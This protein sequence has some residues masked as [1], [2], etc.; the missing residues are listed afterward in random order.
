[1]LLR[2]APGSTGDGLRFGLA[3]GRPRGRA[4]GEVYAR[5]DARAPRADRAEDFVR[6]AQLYARHA[7]VV[8]ERGERFE[9]ATWSEVDV[10]QWTARQPRARAW[11]R[12]P[13][14]RLGERVRERSV[15]DMVDAAAAAGAPVRRG[16][17]HVTVE[18]VAGITTT[19]GGLRVDEHARAAAPACS[20]AGRTPAGSRPAAT[21]AGWRR[22]WC[23]GG[24]RPGRR[25]EGALRRPA[26][27]HAFGNGGPFTIGLEEELLLV[28]PSTF[29]SPTWPTGSCRASTCPR[30]GRPRGLPGRD[31]AALGAVRRHGGGGRAAERGPGGGPGGR[32]D[33]AG[34]RRAPGRGVRRRAAGAH[35]ALRRVEAQ[36]RGLI[37]RTPECAL[38]VHVGVPDPAAAVAVLNG[39]R[40]ALP[41]LHGLGAELAVLVRARLGHGERPGRG[42]PRLPGTRRT[43]RPARLG[44]LPGD[45]STRSAPAAARRTDDGLVGR[46]AAA[47]ARHGRAAG[48]RRAV[49]AS[50]AAAGIAA[51]A[52]ALALRAAEAPVRRPAPDQALHWSSFRAARDGLD[53]EIVLPR[54]PAAAAGGRAGG[55]RGAARRGPGARRR[56][57]HPRRRRRRRPAARRA[58]ARRHAGPARGTWWTR[59]RGRPADRS[60]R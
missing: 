42:H 32:G 40:E 39:L 14:A 52:R 21:R 11:L 43:A 30:T 48:D 49:R 58:R 29:S 31:R 26:E 47:A 9:P 19:L 41:L 1:M 3:A 55:P 36:M 5:A 38:H 25:W 60:P 46:A 56:R 33:A 6:L 4:R 27:D 10:A 8:N 17:E 50:S 45:R 16:A 22:R 54:P 15:G 23:S 20:P 34:R 51:L 37:H 18:T 57:A 35:A 24:S 12:V 28:D 59:R 13:T 44:R 7:E 2:T 53:A